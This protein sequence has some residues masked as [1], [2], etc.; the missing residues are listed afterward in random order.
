M[1][2][3]QV[4][5]EELTDEGRARIRAEQRAMRERPDRRSQ[6]LIIVNTG[7]GKGKTTAA[8]GVLLR[9]WGRGM[10]VCMLQVIKA[11]T[12]NLGE[13]QA[14]R[15]LVMEMIPLGDGFTWT[16]QDIAK[17]RAMAREG[18]ALCRE[19]IAS[20]DYDIVILDEITY[21]FNYGWLDL[22][23]VIAALRERPE[24]LHIVLTGRDAPQELIDFADLGTEMREIKH[25]YKEGVKAQRGI[26]F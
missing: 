3:N 4:L 25:P 14:A 9:A 6:G 23:E 8:L 10:R 17:D 11:R 19:K 21:C 1:A 2:D 13:E 22:G 26:E 12:A 5:P 15:K 18:W 24:G 7:N 20:G 16:L